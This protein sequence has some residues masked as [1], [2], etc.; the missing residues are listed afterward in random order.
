MLRTL[1][2]ELIK[3]ISWIC[4]KLG[5]ALGKIDRLVII[6][7]SQSTSVTFQ[8]IKTTLL[9]HVSF[10]IHRLIQWLGGVHASAWFDL[11]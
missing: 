8:F 9:L 6:I 5:D 2:V 4:L 11:Y 1:N 7:V 10:T 3:L